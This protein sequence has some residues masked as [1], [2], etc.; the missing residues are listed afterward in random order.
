M[1]GTT[2]MTGTTVTTA[3]PTRISGLRHGRPKPAADGKINEKRA[4]IG[5]HSPA[6]WGK[7]EIVY[8][9]VRGDLCHEQTIYMF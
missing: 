4:R 1:T 9:Y 3:I 5:L 8:K 2:A 6:R 7:M